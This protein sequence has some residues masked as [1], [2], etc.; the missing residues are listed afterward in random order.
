MMP[1]GNQPEDIGKVIQQIKEFVTKHGSG[2]VVIPAKPTPDAIAA[3]ISLYLALT[4]L[5]KN[6]SLVASSAVQSDMIG[7]DKIK[8]ELQSGG[9]NLV[10]SFPYQE[11]AI[12]KV[13]YNIQGEQFNLV[14]VPREG[15]SK[16][17]PDDVQFS[18]TGGKIDFIITVDAPNLNALGD[19]Y[20]KNQ[21]QFEGTTIINIDRHLINNSFGMIN[22]ISKSSSSTSELVFKLIQGLNVEIDK[23][24]ATNLHSGIMIAT[25]NFTAYSVNADTF[26]AVASLLRAGAVK[27]PIPFQGGNQFGRPQGGPMGSFGQ[28][29]PAFGGNQFGSSMNQPIN[30]PQMPVQQQQSFGQPNQQ[31]SGE[32]SVQQNTQLN[33]DQPPIV[34]QQQPQPQTKQQQS[35]EIQSKNISE[36]ESAPSSPEGQKISNDTPESFLKPK[37][38][39]GSGGLV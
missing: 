22:L 4:K 16:L 10:V 19:I 30:T 20:N 12:D 1:Q 18:Y 5:G 7:S 21:R 28:R 2:I 38:F 13:D 32:Q 35:F 24:I 9:D 23:D 6:I 29:M 37:I 17:K 39:S 34:N 8:T 33:T 14:I 25:N 27:K 3:G 36:V 26:E 15:H 31:A 11:G